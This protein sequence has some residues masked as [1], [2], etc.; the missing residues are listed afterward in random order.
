MLARWTQIALERREMHEL[1]QPAHLAPWE[2]LKA[3][4]APA[5]QRL[6][7]VAKLARQRRATLIRG[8]WRDASHT[9][10][11]QS[12][13][14][15]SSGLLRVVAA[16]KEKQQQQ[17]QQSSPSQMQ[18]AAVAS[19]CSEAT[20]E[21]SAMGL[22]PAR[23]AVPRLRDIAATNAGGSEPPPPFLRATRSRA[24]SIRAGDRDGPWTAN[25]HLKHPASP[26]LHTTASVLRLASSAEKVTCVR[27]TASEGSNNGKAAN[28][29]VADGEG[30]GVGARRQ[31]QHE[32][33]S[34]KGS[35]MCSM[36]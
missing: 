16:A 27:R 18:A 34:K 14:K 28:A 15:R 5:G 24:D 3:S 10:A 22:L 6:Q 35:S 7:T 11:G 36:M 26:T 12:P 2:A 30:D 25:D 31:Q 19:S 32:V 33:V 1:S 8:K 21:A 20:S 17:Q 23:V 9:A 29:P 13:H 4:V